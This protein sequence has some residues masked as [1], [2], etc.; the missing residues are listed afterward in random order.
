MLI[1]TSSIF[2][3]SLRASSPGERTDP[4]KLQT[5]PVSFRFSER[6]PHLGHFMSFELSGLGFGIGSEPAKNRARPPYRSAWSPSFSAMAISFLLT[7]G[8]SP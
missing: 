3:R 8:Y 6:R 7:T 2:R 5:T 4:Q 1:N